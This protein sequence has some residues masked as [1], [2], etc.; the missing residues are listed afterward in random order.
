[1]INNRPVSGE[2]TTGEKL[3]ELD[4]VRCQEDKQQEVKTVNVLGC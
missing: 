3:T 4:W 1:M 2:G